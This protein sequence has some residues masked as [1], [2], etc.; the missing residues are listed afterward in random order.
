MLLTRRHMITGALSA[1]ALGLGG[2]ASLVRPV[3]V[4]CPNDPRISDPRSHLTIDVHA[5][6]FNGSDVQVERDMTLVQARHTPVLRYLGAI[7]Q[8]IGWEVAPTGAQEIALLREINRYLSNGCG[9]GQFES[10]YA[11]H[12]DEQFRVGVAAL[13]RALFTYQSRRRGFRTTRGEMAVA[14]AIKS[15]PKER[16]RDFINQRRLLR[17]KVRSADETAID[18]AI[19]FVLRQFQYRYVNVF[20]F[21]SGYAA[22]SP[23]KI[24]LAV[25]H[26]IDFDWPL[27]GGR[28]TMTS[29]SEQIDVMEQITIL[30]GGRIHCYAPFDPMKQV[31]YRLGYTSQSPLAL[32][33]SAIS[34]Q[35]FIGVKMYPPMGFA[36]MGNALKNP[37]L[38]H[39]PWLQPELQ[40]PDFGRLL[41]QV[42]LELYTWCIQNNVPIIAHTSKSEGPSGDFEALTDPH[43]WKRVPD[44]L[45]VDFGHFGGTEVSTTNM[46]RALAYCA[47]MGRAGSGAGN[48][49]AD[50]AFLSYAMSNPDDLTNALRILFKTT[51]T[52]G[53]VP[54]AQRLMYGSDWEMLIIAGDESSNYLRN[55]EYIF[56]QL[57]D[58]PS[59]GG[60]GNLADRFFG[61]NAANYLALGS[62]RSTR[63]RLDSFHQSKGVSKP[64]WAQKVDGLHPLVA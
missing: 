20:D 32:V 51:N 37:S 6:V 21:L 52:S 62:G 60:S 3:T 63:N 40:R 16:Y 54:L 30:T 19:A 15:L 57:G 45:R 17:S 46:S 59:L 1:S 5:H 11:A 50:A 29:I 27:A 61:I 35:G 49:Y 47:L 38:W 26:L 24:D 18:A 14:N 36:P 39:K 28:P 23:R 48:F 25:C 7:L 2:C 56:E 22:G 4:F 43:Y 8:D 10:V 55:F 41:D 13:N 44:K 31:A 34:S 33:Q 42:L 12:R 58:D 64:Q 53:P 9:P